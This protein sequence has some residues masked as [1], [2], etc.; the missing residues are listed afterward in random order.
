MTIKFG[1]A[2][3]PF[4]IF[5]I[6]SFSA[7]LFVP[8]LATPGSGFGP[9]P[10]SKAAF[11]PLDIKADKTGKWDLFLKT[12][13]TTDIGVDELSVAPGGFSGW[14]SHAGPTIV[15]VTSGSIVWH[16]S[17]DCSRTTYHAGQG[18][19]EPAN[20]AHYVENASEQAATFI[21][22][23]MRPTG[24]PGRVDEPKPAKC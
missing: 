19:V 22:I 3:V 23:Q 7:S 21:A 20:H 2:V 8:V 4:G 11:G 16:D 9:T 6:A 24:S 12:K 14:H 15:T 18:F 1:K 5:A 10:L 17:F 13:G